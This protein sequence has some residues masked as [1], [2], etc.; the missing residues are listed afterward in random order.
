MVLRLSPIKDSQSWP[1][2]AG[3]REIGSTDGEDKSHENQRH[4]HSRRLGFL[5][6]GVRGH[7]VAPLEAGGLCRYRR[8]LPRRHIVDEVLVWW[9][10]CHPG[11]PML[12]ASQRRS[13]SR[14]RPA[15]ASHCGATSRETR[16]WPLISPNGCGSSAGGNTNWKIGLGASGRA[17][18]APRD[19]LQAPASTV[20][21]GP[22][23]ALA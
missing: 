22:A 16:R 15:I 6:I 9:R 18:A 1:R 13:V 17:G 4:H 12:A 23:M 10:L 5:D 19:R 3:G 2:Q 11:G 7:R 20:R 21:G 14:G 8:Q